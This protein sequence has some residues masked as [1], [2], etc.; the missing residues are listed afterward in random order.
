M[1]VRI[2]YPSFAEKLT[3]SSQNVQQR[4]DQAESGIFGSGSN[5][6]SNIFDGAACLVS[7]VLGGGNPNCKGKGTSTIQTTVGVN[8]GGNDGA[9]AVGSTSSGANVEDTQYNFN[10]GTNKDGTLKIDITLNRGGVC[11][12]ASVPADGKDIKAVIDAVAKKCLAG[13]KN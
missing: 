13:K 6:F 10:Y 8:A 2:L 5:L 4:S 1:L 11:N 7:G 12:Y 3:R 9:V